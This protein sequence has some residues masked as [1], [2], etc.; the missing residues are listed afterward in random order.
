MN[1][2]FKL[3]LICMG[4]ICNCLH[5]GGEVYHSAVGTHYGST[6]RVGAMGHG[7]YHGAG[8][9]GMYGLATAHGAKLVGSKQHP[10]LSYQEL[11]EQRGL[12]QRK[13]AR[14]QR[15]KFAKYPE[16]KK[17]LLRNLQQDLQ[18]LNDRIARRQDFKKTAE[19][20]VQKVKGKIGRRGF[21]FGRKASQ[22]QEATETTSDIG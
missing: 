12:V 15:T 7:I 10:M 4:A 17:T 18:D 8:T 1:K 2:L 9:A 14:L 22:T 20:V 3:L 13:I 16:R 6:G 21:G 11:I 5:A 19:E